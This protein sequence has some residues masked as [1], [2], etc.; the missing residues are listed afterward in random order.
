MGFWCYLPETK[1]IMIANIGLIRKLLI[2]FIALSCSIPL[3]AQKNQYFVKLNGDTIRGR[4]NITTQD[5][6]SLKMRFRTEDREKLTII[7]QLTQHVYH[8]DNIQYGSVP[9]R[10]RRLFMEIVHEGSLSVYNYTRFDTNV[11]RMVS[12]KILVRGTNA[13]EIGRIGFRKSVSG[14]LEGCPKLQ[15]QINSKEYRSSDLVAIAE[16][17]EN[18]VQESTGPQLEASTKLNDFQGEIKNTNGLQG[19]KEILEI[20]KDMQRRVAL[21][22]EIPDYLWKALL[23]SL[24]HAPE[25]K[26]KAEKIQKEL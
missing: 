5:D 17:Y 8:S 25:L 18:C 24:G 20:L 2:F 10:N 16:A 7:P 6:N 22:E 14:F 26:S 13:I 3:I 23:G 15:Q 4:L 19:K 21:N 1:E 9:Y 12:S 11:G